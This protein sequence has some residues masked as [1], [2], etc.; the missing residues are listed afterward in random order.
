MFSKVAGPSQPVQPNFDEV[1]FSSSSSVNDFI[2]QN[3]QLDETY[4]QDALKTVDALAETLKTHIKDYA[5]YGYSVN[6]FVKVISISLH[7]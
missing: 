6:R 4:K 7:L 2:S 3:L 1:D 5:D